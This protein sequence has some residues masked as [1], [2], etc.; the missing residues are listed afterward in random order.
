[1]KRENSIFRRVKGEILD[2]GM[3]FLGNVKLPNNGTGSTRCN[4]V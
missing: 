2:F 3:R 4:I 1:M